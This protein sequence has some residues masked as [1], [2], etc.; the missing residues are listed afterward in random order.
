MGTQKKKALETS[1]PIIQIYFP[2]NFGSRD[3]RKV[4]AEAPR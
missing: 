3:P 1:N 4:A 2:L